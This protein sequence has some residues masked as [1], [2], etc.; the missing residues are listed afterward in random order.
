M[1]PIFILEDNEKQRNTYLEIIENTIMINEIQMK[2]S[3]V[4]DS[5]QQ[6]RAHLQNVNQGLFFLDMEIGTDDTA[7]LQIATEIRRQIPSAKIIFITSHEEL[8]MLTLE[9]KIAP[10]DYILKSQNFATLKQQIIDDILL[11]NQQ[12]KS[13]QYQRPDI[14]NYSIGSRFFSI[15]MTDIMYLYTSKSTPG[16][17]H[18]IGQNQQAEFPGNL[19][20]IAEHYP[21]LFRSDRSYLINID[22]ISQYNVKEH[23]ITFVNGSKAEIS[24]RKSRE[25][26]KILKK[27]SV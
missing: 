16:H 19:S 6:L 1:F 27:R 20:S 12:L 4:T 2:T 23:Y 10:L 25:L 8:A 24:F 22:N 14:F 13:T 26:S 17:V 9:R 3:C 21:L 18:I 7:G 15:P 11:V 5:I